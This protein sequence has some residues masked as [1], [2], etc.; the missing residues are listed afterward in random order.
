M[1]LQVIWPKVNWLNFILETFGLLFLNQMTI[2]L[3]Q[4]H[5]T[6]A[7]TNKLGTAQIGAISKAH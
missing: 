5:L 7:I 6:Q 1:R 4:V 3:S 2:K